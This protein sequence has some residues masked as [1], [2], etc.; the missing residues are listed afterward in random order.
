[1]QLSIIIVNYKTPGLAIDCIRS[2]FAYIKSIAV[3]IIVVDNDSG[4]DSHQLISNEFKNIK[5]IPMSYNS[6]F[7]RAN[8]E[9]I[10]NALG[11]VVLLLNSDALAIDNS[12]EKTYQDFI[13]SDYVAC[14]LQLL[15]ADG[16][17]QISGNFFM[18]GGLNHLLP[19]PYLGNFLRWIAGLFNVKKPHVPDAKDTVEVDWINGAFLMVKRTAFEKAGIMDE[20][21]FLYAEEAEWCSRLGK[22][23]KL[24]IFGEHHIIHLQGVSANEAFGSVGQGYMNLFDRKGLQIILSNILRIRKQYGVFWFLFHL[25]VFLFD[26][27]VFFL[28]LLISKMFSPRS[29]KYSWWQFRGYFNN[30]MSLIRFSKKILSNKPYFY[31]VL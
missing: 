25:S 17:P 6:G 28:G 22:Q 19:L 2:L 4:D 13:V 3:E 8:N 31:K 16:T 5:W 11:D 1:M 27:P 24:C 12:I 26:I 7:A 21:F 14:G 29:S 20:D 9:G 10:R 23:G 30:M 15:N 18:K